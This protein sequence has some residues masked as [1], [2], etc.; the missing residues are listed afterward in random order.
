M[1]ASEGREGNFPRKWQEERFHRAIRSLV[2]RE[3]KAARVFLSHADADRSAAFSQALLQQCRLDTGSMAAIRKG[4]ADFSANVGY[5]YRK[6]EF[7][8]YPRDAAAHDLERLGRSFYV[9]LCRHP[10]LSATVKGQA[11]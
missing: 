1:S 11:R 8:Q 6:P 3:P 10:R 4:L 2:A 5:P 9:A 7:P